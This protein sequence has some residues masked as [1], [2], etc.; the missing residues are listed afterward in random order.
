MIWAQQ[1]E[2]YTMG[3]P[4]Y[5]LALDY[6]RDR[7]FCDDSEF[8]HHLDCVYKRNHCHI[9]ERGGHRFLRP[10]NCVKLVLK[11]SRS[12]FDDPSWLYSYHGTHPSNVSSILRYGLQPGGVNAGGQKVMTAHGG[13]L[14]PGVYTSQI[15]LYAQLYA[16]Y[17]KWRGKYVQTIFMVRQ[18]LQTVTS[19]GCEGCYTTNMIGRVDVHR[20]YGGLIREGEVQ[21][22]T[23]SGYGLVLQALIIKFHDT[24]PE[25][26]GGEYHKI[27]A[28][29]DS[30]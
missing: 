27:K 30:L 3:G 23:K 13:A 21:Y 10:S 1:N 11:R 12:V 8:D 19:D 20:L 29:L 6:V 5:R 2:G 14:G 7:G 17:E 24:P 18:R 15:P 25:A 26:P 4:E 22:V 16:G 28:L 9:E